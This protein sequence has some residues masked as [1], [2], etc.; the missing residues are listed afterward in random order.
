MNKPQKIH[1]AIIDGDIR[2]R[3][4][5]QQLLKFFDSVEITALASDGI[6]AVHTIARQKPDVVFIDVELAG[7]TGFE[8]IAA[9]RRQKVSTRFIIVTENERYA[10][11]ALRN[12]A[13][14]YLIKPV[15][16]EEL[17]NALGK[18]SV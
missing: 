2:A 6:T 13:S 15:D 11:K 18:Q 1:A 3:E 16:I 12:A 14:D 7:M 8:V 4:R 10:I 17:K 5:L 9:L